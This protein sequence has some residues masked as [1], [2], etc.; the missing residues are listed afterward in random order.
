MRE[1]AYSLSQ[2]LGVRIAQCFHPV[3]VARRCG[4][5]VESRR[6][7][8]VDRQVGAKVGVAH[9]PKQRCPFPAILFLGRLYFYG[10]ISMALFLRLYFYDS[11]VDWPLF[12][13]FTL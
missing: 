5:S 10:S 13:S 8:Y 1:H 3:K 7:Y 12:R 6:L 4:R 2:S 11:I 9:H